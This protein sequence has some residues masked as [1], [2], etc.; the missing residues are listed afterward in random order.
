MESNE[1]ILC[2]FPSQIAR[3]ESIKILKELLDDKQN[4]TP[5]DMQ[6]IEF[7]VQTF[8]YQHYLF[9]IINQTRHEKRR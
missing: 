1:L 6:D 8:V 4:L 9:H 2:G 5:A 7:I 3:D